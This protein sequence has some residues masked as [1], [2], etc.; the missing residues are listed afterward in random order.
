MNNVYVLKLAKGKYYVGKSKCV[1]DR[2][3]QHKNG[4]A[5][6]W[7]RKH[8][9]ID[10]IA[11]YTNCDDFDEDKY[12]KLYMREFGIDNV[13]GGTYSQILMP[14]E[15]YDLLEREINHSQNKCMNCGKLGHFAK[16]CDAVVSDDE[17]EEPEPDPEALNDDIRKWFN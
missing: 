8:P 14:D 16:N 2:L 17:Q 9:V 6:F 12:V 10:V 5:A 11:V 15:H 1:I 13:R 7:T 4:E 3:I